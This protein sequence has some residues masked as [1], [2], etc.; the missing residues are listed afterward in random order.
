MTTEEY[1]DSRYTHE[2]YFCD[3]YDI[4]RSPIFSRYPILGGHTMIDPLF[5][6]LEVLRQVYPGG[7]TVLVSPMDYKKGHQWMFVLT[8]S[9]DRDYSSGFEPGCEYRFFPGTSNTGYA[10]RSGQEALKFAR[11]EAHNFDIDRFGEQLNIK[12]ARLHNRHAE[13]NELIESVFPGQTMTEVYNEATRDAVIRRRYAIN[14]L[15]E[16]GINVTT[17]PTVSLLKDDT[18]DN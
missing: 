10:F 1:N 15:K 11:N 12:L 6:S 14:K 7:V 2:Y 5:K 18:N 9:S 4:S 8:D 17:P 3:V 13:D 16:H